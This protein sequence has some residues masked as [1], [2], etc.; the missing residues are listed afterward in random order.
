MGIWAV[1]GQARAQSTCCSIL[2][3]SRSNQKNL[4]IGFKLQKKQ[5]PLKW[6]LVAAGAHSLLFAKSLG[7]GLN[8]ALLSVAGSFYFAP[9]LLKGKV[10]TVQRPK[11]PY[12]A[13]HGSIL[14]FTM[15]KLPVL[16]QLLKFYQCWK[17]ITMAAS[18]NTFR[19]RV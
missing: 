16:V 4:A 19:R 5:L 1:F 13:I 3:S 2:R 11:L 10:Y 15:Q 9:K 7:Y 12:A 18:S 8:Y 14:K 6:L 17:G